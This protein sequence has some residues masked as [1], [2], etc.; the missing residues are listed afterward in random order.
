VRIAGGGDHISTRQIDDGIDP[1]RSASGERPS[2]R[3]ERVGP[4]PAGVE[5]IPVDQRGIR[6]RRLRVKQCYGD[7]Q[8]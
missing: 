3:I 7:K 8:G 5:P 1:L 2:H 6:L 4:E